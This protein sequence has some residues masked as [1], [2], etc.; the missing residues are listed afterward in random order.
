M[1]V[2][3]EAAKLEHA[4]ARGQESATI[5]LD[6]RVC[7]EGFDIDLL[8][9]RYRQTGGDKVIAKVLRNHWVGPRAVKL[10]QQFHPQIAFTRKGMPAGTKFNQVG[11]VAY[12]LQAFD[13][14]VQRHPA[15]HFVSFIDDNYLG[16]TGDRQVVVQRATRAA[17][18]LAHVFHTEL[19]IRFAEGKATSTCT[20]PKLA[21]RLSAQIDKVVQAM[22]A[23][24]GAVANLGVDLHMP[25]ARK[26][27]GKKRRQRSQK[28]ERFA[29]KY[30]EVRKWARCKSK[31]FRRVYSHQLKPATAFGA[32]VNG[33]DTKELHKLRNALLKATTPYHGSHRRQLALKGDPA[34]KEALALFRMWSRI[35]WLSQRLTEPQAKGIPDLLELI[36]WWGKAKERYSDE[37][38]WANSRGPVGRAFLALK[39]IEWQMDDLHKCTTRQGLTINLGKTAPA[40]LDIHLQ[41]ATQEVHEKEMAITMGEDMNGRVCADYPKEIA[42]AKG[43][44]KWKPDQSERFVA[45]AAPIGALWCR[46]DFRRLG[47]HAPEKCPLCEEKDSLLHRVW[48]CMHPDALKARRD[49]A[50]EWFIREVKNEPLNPR[51]VTGVSPHPTTKRHHEPQLEIGGFELKTP[52]GSVIEA[53]DFN[54]TQPIV[55]TDGSA[56]VHPVWELSHAAWSVVYL[57]TNYEIEATLTGPVWATLPQTSQD[58]EQ[59]GFATPLCTHQ[60]L[61][62]ILSDSATTINMASLPEHKQI[63]PNNMYA[64]VQKTALNDARHVSYRTAQ[65]GKAHKNKAAKEARRRQVQKS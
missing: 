39:R 34:W 51:W 22:T 41:R 24:T 4:E 63:H 62:S 30:A 48:Y 37:A 13:R 55:A 35:L 7:Y 32:A 31:V 50:P 26:R 10:R 18:D 1:H 42:K 56:Y 45:K 19:K 12:S 5:E 40:M 21:S 49:N 60:A 15:C 29:C 58:I 8:R 53:Q 43:T 64:G 46:D 27:Q 6:G 14:F 36:S 16:V 28:L 3:I 11:V 17:Q 47:Y 52:K 20:C 59:V 9:I 44:K 33:L 65:H 23:T 2:F 38:T 57:D 25:G 61:F 54:Y